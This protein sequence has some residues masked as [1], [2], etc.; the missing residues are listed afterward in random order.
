M[1]TFFPTVGYV[2]LWE[3]LRVVPVGKTCWYQGIK[4]GIYPRPVKISQ[5]CVAWK[6]EDIQVLIK[7]IER[8]QADNERKAF[9]PVKVP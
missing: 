1:H 5:R 2:R 6:A 8:Q 9:A 4:D 3:V 7:E